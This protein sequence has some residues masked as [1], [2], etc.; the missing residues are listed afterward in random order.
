MK[1]YNFNPPFF[2]K[3]G[4]IQTILNSQ[5]FIKRENLPLLNNS[6]D[7]TIETNKGIKLL[8]EFSKQKDRESKGFILLIHGWEGSSKSEYVVKN[9]NYLYNAGYDIFRLNMRDHGDSHHL[10]NDIFLGTLIDEVFEASKNAIETQ[11]KNKK[12]F[13]IGYS[14]GANFA[15]RIAAKTAKNKIKNLNHVVAINPPIDP[16]QATLNIDKSFLIRK[17]FVKKWKTSL[18]KKMDAKPEIYDFSQTLELK[19]CIDITKDLVENFSEFNSIKEYF[20]AYNLSN[21]ILNNVGVPTTI[22]MSEDDPIIDYNDFKNLQLHKNVDISMQK[23]GGH[24]GYF[25]NKSLDSWYES[26]LVELFSK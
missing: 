25:T 13:I 3:N 14:L 23:Y 12:S 18:Q 10:N 1:N 6:E 16:Y 8:G 11:G 22:L 20:S 19:T 17:N 7:L 5:R 15:L 26:K 4:M 2:L 24:C 9:G 21:N